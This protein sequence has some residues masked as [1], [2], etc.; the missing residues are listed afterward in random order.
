M[1]WLTSLRRTGAALLLLPA[2]LFA[3]TPT[4]V[5]IEPA[6][7][8]LKV[9]ESAQLSAVVKDENGNVIPDSQVLFFGS[10]MS[11][12]ITPSGFVTAVRPGDHSIT[13]MAP[14]T[15]FEG[16]PDYYT[17]SFTPG[18][19]GKMELHVPVPP[20]VSIE[21]VDMPDVVYEGTS[22][23]VRIKGVD[24]TGVERIDLVP[25]LSIADESI[26][27]TDGF[28]TVTGLSAGATTITAVADDVETQFA[29]EVV[30]NPVRSIDMTASMKEARTGDVIHFNA[31]ARDAGGDTVDDVPIMYSLI[32]RPDPAHPDAR[33]AGASA[34]IMDDGRFV[35]EQQ[36][37]YTVVAMTGDAV[38]RETVRIEQRDVGREF[39]FL[40]LARIP[41]HFTSDLWVW[42]SLHDGRDY[43][44]VGSWGGDGHAYFYDVTDPTNM[45]LVDTVQIDARTVND[46]KISED[47]R[48]GILS[49]EGASNRRNGI[50][51]L[52][53]SNP[54]DVK[55][56]AAYDDQMT[57]GVHNVFIADSHV[58]SVNNGRRF[59][60]INIEDPA[61]PRRVS[62]FETDSPG[63][64]VHDVWVHD[65]IAYQAGRTD[66]VIMIDVGG[67]GD[68]DASP[69]NPVEMGRV[70]QITRWN[71]AVWPFRKQ[72]C[73]Q[74]LRI[75]RRRNLLYQPAHRGHRP[76]RPG[77]E[78]CQ[79]GPA[80]GFTSWSS[81]IRRIQRRSPATG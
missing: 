30:S 3:Q 51:I 49:R 52:D 81:M 56:V 13:A 39:E 48:V 72:E 44:L 74:V 26:A 4:T 14:E 43:A 58:Y 12:N 73:G 27:E 60:I 46:V 71:H 63:R 16:D 37:I 45:E 35:A 80:A 1:T 50:V 42:E 55:I 15:P 25:S 23:T 76:A 36:G 47:G 18:I 65:G 79:P 62:R 61:N 17:R 75:C 38:A 20:V 78:N 77:R 7:L 8:T 66:G 34:M 68:N 19:R 10:R 57:G 24:E 33:G 21:L 22:V 11:M 64:S 6:E 5:E 70:D 28:G 54:R 41:G 2:A 32:N 40:G 31:V 69:E 53:T 9:G 59:D 67:G 29:F